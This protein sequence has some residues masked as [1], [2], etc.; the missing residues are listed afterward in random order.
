MTQLS[1]TQAPYTITLRAGIPITAGHKI[2]IGKDWIYCSLCPCMGSTCV[3]VWGGGYNTNIP[4]IIFLYAF[5][6]SA[7]HPNE[8]LLAAPDSFL[9]LL[10]EAPSAWSHLT[11][12][13]MSL[14]CEPASSPEH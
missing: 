7:Q 13:T 6:F 9:I 12:E 10:R 1:H 4:V 8:Q 2:F 14:L 3:G 5:S 11:E